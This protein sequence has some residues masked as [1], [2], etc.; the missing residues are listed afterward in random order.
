MPDGSSSAEKNEC[1]SGKY[2]DFEWMERNELTILQ[3]ASWRTVDKYRLSV[4]SRAR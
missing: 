3:R 2:Q 4:R 1:S